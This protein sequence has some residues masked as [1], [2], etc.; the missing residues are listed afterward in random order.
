M[1]KNAV[2]VI[3]L[4]VVGTLPGA[5][6][7]LPGCGKGCT[8]DADCESNVPGCALVCSHVMGIGQCVPAEHS[9]AY[10]PRPSE[11]VDAGAVVE[12]GTGG[13]G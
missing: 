10:C 3:A 8:T 1:L 11:S 5:L 6:I 4:A 12:N 9:P 13:G 7:L 2:V